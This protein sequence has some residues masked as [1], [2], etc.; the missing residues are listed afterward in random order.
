[1]EG[2][3]VWDKIAKFADTLA[4]SVKEVRPVKFMKFRLGI[5]N[6]AKFLMKVDQKPLIQ[7]QKEWYLLILDNLNEAGIL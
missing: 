5:P 3:Q 2:N 6:D 1:M 4:L 7:V